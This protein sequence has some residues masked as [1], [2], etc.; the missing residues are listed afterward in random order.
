[1]FFVYVEE[2]WLCACLYVTPCAAFTFVSCS[3]FVSI[4]PIPF[5]RDRGWFGV[6]YCHGALLASAPTDCMCSVCHPPT[7]S[8]V[9]VRRVLQWL[10]V[11]V[12]GVSLMRVAVSG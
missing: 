11:S 9:Y 10:R 12:P 8:A 6:G 4:G 3:V 1:M 7:F 2:C 5:L